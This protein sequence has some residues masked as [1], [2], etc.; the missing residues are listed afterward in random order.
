[1]QNKA[2]A[3]IDLQNDITK[4][5]KDVIVNVN[6]AIDRAVKN[7]LCVIYV[8]HE[9]LSAGTKTFK[10]G[11]SGAEFVPELKI[12]SDNI[13]TKYKQNI[14][15]N[16]ELADF[17]VKNKIGEFYIAGADAA[18]CVKS[19]CLNLRKAKYE[20]NVLTDCITSY[21]KTKI[22]EMLLYYESKG[23]RLITQKDL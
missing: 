18:F 10:H 5:Y 16:K 7:G 21:D 20:V 13:F 15:S 17:I 12:V 1:M 9:N 4:N 23:C 3:V 19:S 22:P 14:L 2:L 8:R 11:T 6:S